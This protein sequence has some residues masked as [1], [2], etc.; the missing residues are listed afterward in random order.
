MDAC[1]ACGSNLGRSERSV[2]CSGLCGSVFHPG[3]V[4]LNAT[5]FKAWTAN[6]GLLWFCEHCR[7]NF[8]PSIIDREAVIIKTMRD[9]LTRVDSMDLR[10]GQF[11]E[12]LKSM[13][14]LL[15]LTTSMRRDSTVSTRPQRF[16]L[17]SMATHDPS[18]FYNSIARL[19]LDSTLQSNAANN[20]I[21]FPDEIEVELD[22][23]QSNEHMSRG[24]LPRT[25]AA[26][27]AAPIVSN[28]SEH[29]SASIIVPAARTTTIANSATSV[30]SV[31]NAS[32]ATASVTT[33]S[34][35][36]TAAATPVPRVAFS[37]PIDDNLSSTRASAIVPAS[38]D[39]NC[40]LK[41]VNRNRLI[42]N[43]ETPDEPLKSFYVTP[44]TVE[45]T[46]EDII[47]YLRETVSIDDSTVKCV[48]LVP[49]NKNI[50]ELSFVSF[51]VSVS[52]NLASVIGDRFYWPEG[53]E[54]REF[55][56]KNGVRL[57]QPIQIQ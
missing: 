22:D 11:G 49:R 48:K 14:G 28:A 16:P 3:C 1:K 10:I 45:Q 20:S 5:N 27:V 34:V 37:I 8:N 19:N 9:L 57:N 23:S 53:V 2:L 18:D 43:R 52:E 30:T 15:S 4:G 29:T 55:Q 38:H 41:V 32:V 25:Y 12:N 44:F 54:I 13:Y 40:R 26:A 42:A 24:D 50:S 47:E 35:T 39:E 17:S 6:V 56:P 7:I 36:D 33:A 31:A 46:E 21:Q 51:K